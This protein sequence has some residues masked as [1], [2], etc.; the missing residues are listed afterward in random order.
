MTLGQNTGF[1]SFFIQIRHKFCLRSIFLAAY[2]NP[3]LLKVFETDIAKD[4]D[5]KIC[6]ANN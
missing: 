3:I 4:E 6:V 1:S 5:K 2:L